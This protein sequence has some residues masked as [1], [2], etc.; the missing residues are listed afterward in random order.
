MILNEAFPRITDELVSQVFGKTSGIHNG[1]H[2]QEDN[3]LGELE[4]FE[5]GVE[6]ALEM[7][8]IFSPVTRSEL[9]LA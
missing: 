9:N 8:N 7:W 5:G 4:S 6:I 1:A 2:L 3:N